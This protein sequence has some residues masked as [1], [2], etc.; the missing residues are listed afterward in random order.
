MKRGPHLSA[1]PCLKVAR[2][3]P[4]AEWGPR[5][6]RGAPEPRQS[7]LTTAVA[8]VATATDGDPAT[9]S[10]EKEVPRCPRPQH[11]CS[12][13]WPTIMRASRRS[14][15][16]S[17]ICRSPKSIAQPCGCGRGSARQSSVCHAMTS[18]NGACRPLR[19]AL[20]PTPLPGAAHSRTTTPQ[21]KYGTRAVGLQRTRCFPAD[22]QRIT[23]MSILQPLEPSTLLGEMRGKASDRGCC[24]GRASTFD[25]SRLIA[26]P[27]PARPILGRRKCPKLCVGTNE[28]DD[29]VY[30]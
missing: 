20:R 6:I 5:C 1:P 28:R 12:R 10:A 9:P 17:S 11:Y 19:P 21:T 2:S 24:L 30:S 25:L 14:R 13:T 7:A 15:T 16:S 26:P 27:T 18:W 22:F 4:R 29:D 23:P 8:G 3:G